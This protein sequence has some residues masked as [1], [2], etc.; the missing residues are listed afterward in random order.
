[1]RSVLYASI[2][3]TRFLP[4]LDISHKQQEVAIGQARAARDRL[5]LLQA[6]GH[7]LL[8]G[9]LRD[10][11]DF[12]LRPWKERD[13]VALRRLGWNNDGIGLPDRTADA[14]A[15]ERASPPRMKL[16]QAQAGQVMHGQNLPAVAL[17]QEGSVDGMEHVDR[18]QE[19]LD[20]QPRA[21][22]GHDRRQEGEEDVRHGGHFHQSGLRAFHDNWRD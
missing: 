5:A 11:L 22:T 17:R 13:E 2:S 10:D 12:A 19:G 15:E 3:A 21:P 18:S 1:M 9:R 14:Q 4:R 20:S 6:E 7:E 16:W 8:T